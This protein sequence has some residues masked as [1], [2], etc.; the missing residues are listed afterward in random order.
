MKKLPIFG[1][2]VA[3]SILNAVEPK[4]APVTEG[5]SDRPFAEARQKDRAFD[6]A[7]NQIGVQTIGEVAT[8]YGADRVFRLVD[9]SSWGT[10]V[11]TVLHLP[12]S[13]VWEGRLK[14]ASI[15]W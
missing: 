2:I 8:T 10:S 11:F 7:L 15:I 1:A 14:V 6:T 12:K 9:S 3:A 4:S 5:D 13:E